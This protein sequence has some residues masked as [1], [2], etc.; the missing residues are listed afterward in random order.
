MTEP[1]GP[2]AAGSDHCNSQPATHGLQSTLGWDKHHHRA[3]LPAMPQ[4]TLGHP[5][6]GGCVAAAL[7][8][9]KPTFA[10]QTGRAGAWSISRACRNAPSSCCNLA[11]SHSLQDAQARIPQP[12]PPSPS[13]SPFA[14][15]TFLSPAWPAG[16]WVLA[17]GGGI[18]ALPRAGAASL[19]SGGQ[20]G[21]EA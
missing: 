11:A 3:C 12:P 16:S 15:G 20:A 17:K 5:A 19:G 2:G 7:G 18:A 14:S 10:P 9:V 21:T 4:C 13:R 6:W 1:H 8:L